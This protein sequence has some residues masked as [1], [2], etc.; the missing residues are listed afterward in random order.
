MAFSAK[1]RILD[2]KALQK[3]EAEEAA[4]QAE[5]QAKENERSS[6]PAPASSQMQ[7]LTRRQNERDDRTESPTPTAAPEDNWSDPDTASIASRDSDDLY[8][9]RP[10]RWRGNPRAWR[11]I[12]ENDRAVAAALWRSRDQD[13]SAHLYNAF[14]MKKSPSN[15][16]TPGNYWTAWP[17]RLEDNMDMFDNANAANE[18]QL[19]VGGGD[20]EENDS[21][22]TFRSRHPPVEA[23]PSGPLEEMLTATIQ[24]VAR[25][26]FHQRQKSHPAE[27]G[28]Q[29]AEVLADDELAEKLL[30]PSVRHLLSQTDKVLSILHNTRVV[31]AGDTTGLADAPVA[32]QPQPQKWQRA[33]SVDTDAGT[34]RIGRPWQFPKPSKKRT[35]IRPDHWT[36]GPRL[37]MATARTPEQVAASISKFYDTSDN[38]DTLSVAFAPV[39][40][41]MPSRTRK[42]IMETHKSTPRGRPRKQKERLPG[43]TDKEYLIR[44]AR[45]GHR[46]IPE[47]PDEKPVRDEGIPAIVTPI[48]PP[49]ILQTIERRVSF[50]DEVQSIPNWI[51]NVA[52]YADVEDEESDEEREELPRS[53]KRKPQDPSVSNDKDGPSNSTIAGWP[54]RNWTDVIGAAALSGGFSQE[55]LARTAQRCAD[56]FG[57][58]MAL[59]TMN[60]VPG[61]TGK[62]QT[63]QEQRKE[64]KPP[65]SVDKVV[66]KP[67][68][69]GSPAVKP[70]PG[71]D[72]LSALQALK[73]EVQR[74]Q[75][76]GQDRL[77]R[78]QALM[79]QVM[80]RAMPSIATN[81]VAGE[82]EAE[83]G[84]QSEDSEDSEEADSGSEV[85]DEAEDTRTQ[86]KTPSGSKSRSVSVIPLPS[87]SFPT[88]T[89]G[90]EPLGTT[91]KPRAKPGPQPKATPT[92]YYCPRPNCPRAVDG[93]PRRP[94][95]V[96]HMKLVHGDI[97]DSS[98]PSTAQ[99]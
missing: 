24:R 65:L 86:P 80:G 58:S 51:R 69:A 97:I 47:F 39:Q 49:F 52:S 18:T 9:R 77:A 33:M 32:G 13:L 61:S 78:R 8:A 36:P 7:A 12:T 75:A 79:E 90:P 19:D 64:K 22:W 54:L 1:K 66:F 87:V 30:H 56:L 20:G 16:W 40:T 83:D 44:I 67:K 41:S 15:G 63:L 42:A 29:T 26:Q 92:L 37:M 94:N 99:K 23:R 17:L 4:R 28:E 21:L 70:E 27:D 2:R 38:K 60:G 48:P 46:R 81:V 76:Q 6:P 57:E 43:E 34:R 96:R 11:H 68:Q 14:F 74:A 73:V 71:L 3:A 10:N 31:M 91:P 88:G 55:V 72:T 89:A 25:E 62:N 35:C 93:F 5:L 95:M 59:S 82:E 50:S 98:R 85:D 84:E 53:H 45:E